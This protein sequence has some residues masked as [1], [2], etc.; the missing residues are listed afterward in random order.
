[1][2]QEDRETSQL[3]SEKLAR[4]QQQCTFTLHTWQIHAVLPKSK[5]S[6]SPS[7]RYQADKLYPG[8]KFGEHAIRWYMASHT[9]KTWVSTHLMWSTGCNSAKTA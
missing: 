9:S 4:E 7:H 6:L 2:A 8:P 5:G 1:M 3:A